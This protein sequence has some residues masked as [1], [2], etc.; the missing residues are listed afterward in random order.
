MSRRV[1]VASVLALSV[2]S[3]A[4]ESERGR[5]TAAT[6]VRG[7]ITD[8]QCAASELCV[9]RLCS[10]RCGEARRCAHKDTACFDTERGSA[11]LNREDNACVDRDDCPSDATCR[12]GRCAS[13]CDPAAGESCGDCENGLCLTEAEPEP[14][15]TSGRM[16]RDAGSSEAGARGVGR[17]RGQRD[18]GAP[19]DA[20]GSESAPDAGAAD[21]TPATECRAGAR[22]CEGAMAMVCRS[23]RF[24][25]AQSCEFACRDGACAGACEAGA[26]TCRNGGVATCNEDGEWGTPVACEHA[27]SDG[28]CSGEC[29]PGSRRCASDA[30]Y[31]VC[32]R[33]G[34]WGASSAC[35]ARA[36]VDGSCTGACTPGMTRCDGPALA[37][38]DQVGRWGEAA[39]CPEQACESGACV[40]ARCAPENLRCAPD[41]SAQPQLCDGDGR[42]RDTP[43]CTPTQACVE[44]V[45][46]G[47]CAPGA[48]RCVPT[49]SRSY[50]TCGAS[51]EWGNASACGGEQRC[52]GNGECGVGNACPT[53]MSPE[54]W[55]E[56]DGVD[57]SA[58]DPRWG[59]G[60]EPFASGSGDAPAGYAIVFDRRAHE[61][62][63]TLRTRAEDVA[64]AA[65]SVYFGITGNT[66]AT[67]V[68][69]A[70][71]IP[72]VAPNGSDD[73]RALSQLIGYA[74]M[75]G[76]WSSAA[77]AAQW[78]E[79]PA[80]WVA[81]DDAGWLVSF[82]VDLA[83][84]GV[85][86]ATSFRVAL[87]LHA[88]TD[89]EDLT[90]V[91]PS[92]LTLADVSA[93]DPRTWSTLNV[94][95]VD[96][97]SRVDVQ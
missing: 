87:G 48:R 70:V 25:A 56:A 77:T 35:G 19:E 15:A 33:R 22:T 47:E 7:C 16:A 80:A 36:C 82:R 64:D 68:P 69:R 75:G 4:C 38:C 88:E 41:D 55:G 66:S 6:A 84:V 86:R 96:C 8:A 1:F 53:G 57:R 60:L 79:H 12:R 83:A 27:C 17:E 29:T 45:C 85:D 44:G 28:A 13:D 49:D 76:A 24:V 30:S 59:G 39:P 93:V 54:W 72:L 91:T 9:F 63:V 50:Q 71:R 97:T 5:F 46:R 21:D 61:L 43:R 20:G 31:Q 32:D 94:S 52:A 42:W 58:N 37:T 18:A 62:A 78:V 74:Y 2:G 23:G 11:C 65:D 81:G 34:T 73:P 95:L 14:R 3:Y 51:G 90:W 67:S 40:V 10:P 92:D 89:S 26:R